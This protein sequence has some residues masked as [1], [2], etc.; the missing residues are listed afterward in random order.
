[1]LHTH[2]TPQA[3]DTASTEPDTSPARPPTPVGRGTISVVLRVLTDR[4]AAGHLV[5]QAEVVDTGEIV[6]VHDQDDLHRLIRRLAA[7][8]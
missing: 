2:A 6:R 3:A 8:Q 7:G 4:A 5:G 1:M